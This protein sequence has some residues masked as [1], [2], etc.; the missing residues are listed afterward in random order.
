MHGRQAGIFMI[1]NHPDFDNH[2]HVLFVSTESVGLKG[3]IALHSTVLGPAAGGCRMY[4]YAKC[5]K[6]S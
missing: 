6:G 4:P 3:I 1:F 2:E 5:R